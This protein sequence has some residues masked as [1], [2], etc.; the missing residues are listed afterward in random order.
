MFRRVFMLAAAA[1]LLV[2]SPTV[3]MADYEA[4]GYTSSVSDATP[5][6]GQCINMWV[7]GGTANAGEVYTL[8]VT[9]PSTA[10]LTATANKK[11]VVR[12]R[13]C[14]RELG[15][16]TL[17]ARNSAGDL[18]AEQTITVHAPGASGAAG[19]LS[20]TGSDV[21]PLAGGGALLVLLG[22]GAVVV[23]RRRSPDQ[24]PA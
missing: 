16:Y 5:V 17:T 24:V 9:G 19:Q 15:D 8:D 7:S 21:L 18:V 4:P 10:S 11:G 20:S 22:V 3:A 1:A 6:A 2:L 14:L 23:A 12:F 13:V